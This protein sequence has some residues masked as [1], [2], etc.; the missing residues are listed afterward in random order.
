MLF[1]NPGNFPGRCYPGA[2]MAGVRRAM[3]RSDIPGELVIR[4]RSGPAD[5]GT[6]DSHLFKPYQWVAIGPF[7]AT[8]NPMAT[9]YP[10][11]QNVDLYQDYAGAGRKTAIRA[12]GDVAV[13]Q[14]Y[15][16]IALNDI[17]ETGN[18]SAKK[19]MTELDTSALASQ[20]TTDEEAVTALKL[21]H[22]RNNVGAMAALID[23]AALF[24]PMI[25]ED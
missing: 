20:A 19:I 14:P 17:V 3:A 13:T 12:L 23:A 2:V 15:A 6:I 8:S 10:P 16:A 7:V 4:A 25:R 9:T 11:E 21:L 18:A 24:G 5:L 1:K 22:E